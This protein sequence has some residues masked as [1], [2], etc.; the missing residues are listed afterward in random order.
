MK[1][2]IWLD[3]GAL[4]C[5]ARTSRHISKWYLQSLYNT[6]N[7]ME[8][9][10]PDK[11]EN[12]PESKRSRRSQSK[13]N[14]EVPRYECFCSKQYLSYPALYLHLKNKHQQHFQNSKNGKKVETTKLVESFDS[15]EGFKVYKISIDTN[16]EKDKHELGGAINKAFEG[17]GFG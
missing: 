15:A 3:L 13:F 1:V 14:K 16:T 5:L 9:E 4:S 2:L 17:Q 8:R 12:L 10:I 7:I 11:E 6:I